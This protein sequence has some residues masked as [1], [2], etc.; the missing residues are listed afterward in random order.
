MAAT[1]KTGK[2]SKREVER[3]YSPKQLAT[4]LHRLAECLEHGRPY[5]LSIA[6]RQV[7]V[8]PDAK[9]SLEHERE[10]AEEALELEL[11]WKG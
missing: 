4:K 7:V 11:K 1:R 8:P 3:A 5:R 6:G 2:R 10:G 9:I